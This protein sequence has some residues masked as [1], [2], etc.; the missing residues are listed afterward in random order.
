MSKSDLDRSPGHISS[1]GGAYDSTKTRSLGLYLIAVVISG[2][3]F[4]AYALVFAGVRGAAFVIAPIVLL[5][6]NAAAVV[7]AAMSTV[8]A[9]KEAASRTNDVGTWVALVGG[10]SMGLS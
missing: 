8:A 2:F 4:T 6:P 5:L 1:S 9:L 10:L 7:L 3:S